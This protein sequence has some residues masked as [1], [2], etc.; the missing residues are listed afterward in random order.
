M[1]RPP[2]L[3][4]NAG[5]AVALAGACVGAYLSVGRSGAVASTA[6]RT[7]KVARGPVTATVT[8]SGNIASASTETLAFG[9]AGT[10]TAVYVKVGERVAK[11]RAIARIDDTPAKIALDQAKAQLLMAQASYTRTAAGQTSIEAAKNRNA[12]DRASLQLTQAKSSLAAA[13]KQ[14]GADTAAQDTLV[15]SALAAYK[16][17]TGTKA[18]WTTA[19][20]TRSGAL[21]RDRL[22]VRQARIQYNSAL[23][24][25][26]QAKDTA[27]TA[28]AGPA[29]A[30]LANASSSLAQAKQ[31]VAVARK[32]LDATVLRADQA[33]TV[34]SVS[35]YVGQTVSAGTS[36]ITKGSSP[37]NSSSSSGGGD[38][39]SSTSSGASGFAVVADLGHLSVTANIAEADASSVAVGQS[40]SITVSSTNAQ[41]AGKVTEV[42]LQ[43]STSNNVVQYPVTV[44]VD[45]VATAV[46]LGATVS[47]T[48][49]TGSR[50]NT[51]VVPSSAVSTVGN[52]HTVTVIR[53]NVP[54]TVPVEQGLSG[55][56]G[57]E[58]LAGLSE[59]ETV[60]LTSTSSG[61]SSSSSSGGDGRPGGLGGLGGPGGMP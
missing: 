5:L 32:T 25:L 9:A 15:A 51:L 6:T 49:T 35:G 42:S 43:S 44:T 53:N 46:K 39:P 8:G 3:W 59:G 13:T 57:V 2:G 61:S 20:S 37:S 52:R 48:I 60:Q 12:I 54:T 31:A 50:T 24:D 4:L 45:A 26:A 40:A 55:D 14:L 17:G 34:L 21:S 38:G 23:T 19:V 7:V 47:L 29:A 22:A 30:D 11:G 41:L 58:I 56:N 27:A 10:V 28:A 16:A 1:K 18:A 36:T 33:G